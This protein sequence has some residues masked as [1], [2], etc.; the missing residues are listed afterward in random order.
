M[1]FIALIVAALITF[2]I[3]RLVIGRRM[4]RERT[5]YHEAGHAV[6]ACRLD[7]FV[8]SVSIIE[9][10]DHR[11]LTVCAMEKSRSGTP[12]E[13]PIPDGDGWDEWLMKRA[14]FGV[15]GDVAER[16]HLGSTDVEGFGIYDGLVERDSDAGHLSDYLMQWP[17]ERHAHE[18]DR[19]YHKAEQLVTGHWRGIE[20]VARALLVD[21]SLDHA[22][23]MRLLDT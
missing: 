13:V 4:A 12:I 21:R 2:A 15:A 22:A 14:V 7:F 8:E 20:K 1:T 11:G 9:T 16:F 5:A 6:V 19:L 17:T 10:E 3:A 18:R 23:L